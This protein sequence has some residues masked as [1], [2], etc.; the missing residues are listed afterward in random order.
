MTTI[1]ESLGLR[2]FIN[3]RGTITTLGG[4]IMS[5]EVVE[6]MAEASRHFVHLNEL[7][8]K[9]GLRIAE[10]TGAEAAFICAGAASGLMLAGAAC[11]TGTNSDAIQKLPD[12]EGR[13]NEFV[14]SLVDSHY[15]V[16]QGFVVCGGQ[17]VKI[18]S[19]QAVTPEDYAAAITE[20]T[21]A[22]VFFLGSQPNEQL[23]A[24]IEV[25]HAQNVP[26]IVD[27]A[28]QL[29]PRCNLSDLTAMGVDLVVFSG[30]KGLAGPQ[31]SGLVLGRADL[32]RACHLNSNPHSAVGRGMKV[33][34][35]EI[36]GLLKA[37][38]L[39]YEMDEEAVVN[40]WNRRCQ[41]I[42]EAVGDIAD[43][44]ATFTKAYEN[45]FPPASP[46]V[47]LHMGSGAPK[48]AT[49]VRIELEEGTPSILTSGGDSDITLGPQTL[50]EGEAELIAERLRQII[51]S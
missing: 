46:L 11:L 4:S 10:L 6:A 36:A 12:T 7:H 22:A 26:V 50:Q 25:A 3:A 37:V 9:A 32:V 23:P 27:A 29:P 19:R 28:A 39:F 33:G 47:H 41:L 18:G 31:S 43:I 8:E 20:R 38:E 16:H 2:T 42:G 24:V 30:G 17:L 40:E 5:P 51:A 44:E 35:E 34:K 1:Y 45:Q 14:I 15:Y 48:T 49:Q 21:A 13:A